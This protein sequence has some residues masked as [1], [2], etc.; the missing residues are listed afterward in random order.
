MTK[1]HKVSNDV[2]DAARDLQSF[3]QLEKWRTC[4]IG[5]VAVQRWGA[6]RFTQDADITVRMR[7]NRK[8]DLKLVWEEVAP[9]SEAKDEPEILYWLRR[10]VAVTIGARFAPRKPRR[11]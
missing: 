10:L 2:L 1:P 3:C 9:L 8:L 5:G 11:A 4:F 6:P 7:Q